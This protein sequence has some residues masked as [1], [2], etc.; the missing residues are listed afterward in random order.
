MLNPCVE[1]GKERVEGKTWIGRSGSSKITYT[2]TVCPDPN[3]QKKVDKATADRKI[4]STM[5]IKKKLDAK[6][7]REK[8][9]AVN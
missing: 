2:Q 3:C 8:L 4:K 6:L 9:Q 1:C 7:A 5:L